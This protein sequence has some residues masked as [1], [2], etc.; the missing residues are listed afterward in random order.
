M[1]IDV[2]A[3]NAAF[4]DCLFRKEELA[5]QSD[6]NALHSLHGYKIPDTAVRV[7]GVQMN[8]GFHPD[9]LRSHESE[10]RRWLMALPH[11]FRQSV[12]GGWSF[13]NACDDEDGNQWTGLHT[14]MEQLFTLGIGLGLVRELMPGMRGALP[15]A[16]PYYV[17]LDTLQ[18][19]TMSG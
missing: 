10:V 2:A 18:A 8:V 16:M 3:V 17:V 13:L 14:N 9:R 7:R 15:G 4:M 6:G 12:G 5:R 11:Q 1:K 19:Q